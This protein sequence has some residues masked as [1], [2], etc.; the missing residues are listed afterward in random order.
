MELPDTVSVEEIQEYGYTWDGMLPLTKER[1]LEMDE[2]GLTIF[3][4]TTG[5]AEG[6]LENKEDILAH[7]GLFGVEKGEWQHYLEEQKA[8]EA[9]GMLPGMG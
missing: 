3:R 9:E 6:M 8:E 4:L 2:C 1:A 5:G 7:D